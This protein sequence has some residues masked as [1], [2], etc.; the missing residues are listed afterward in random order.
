MIYCHFC[1]VFLVALSPS[2]VP[3]L[4]PTCASRLWQDQIYTITNLTAEG[5]KKKQPNVSARTS[6]P[7]SVKNL[8]SFSSPSPCSHVSP[9]TTC[10]HCT[11]LTPLSP[12]HPGLL[13]TALMQD[14]VCDIRICDFLTLWNLLS[15][16]HCQLFWVFFSL[17]KKICDFFEWF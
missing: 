3:P 9:R 17:W 16:C 11:G 2:V 1:F 6:P 14:C 12:W 10:S 13:T 15:C 8:L 7:T 4:F 5:S